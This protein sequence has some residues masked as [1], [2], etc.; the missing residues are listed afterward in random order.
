MR[1]C[2]GKGVPS[3]WKFN[4]IDLDPSDMLIREEEK[5]AHSSRGVKG[6]GG[7]G[8]GG[9]RNLFTLFF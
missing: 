8:G 2:V 6:G 5:G 7:G 3:R 4:V 1:V 9:Y